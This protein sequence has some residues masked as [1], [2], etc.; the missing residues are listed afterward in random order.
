MVVMDQLITH[1]AQIF[2]ILM[3]IATG[4]SFIRHRDNLRRDIALM[5][6]SVAIAVT[7]DLF[8]TSS[9]FLIGWLSQACFRLWGN[10]I[11]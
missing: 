2:F 11:C 4:I 7:A 5:F 3:G 6:G 10:P 1:L 9:A 8:A